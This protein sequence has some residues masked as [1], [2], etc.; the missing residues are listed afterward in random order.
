MSFGPRAGLGGKPQDGTE[1]P[2]TWVVRSSCDRA[3]CVASATTVNRKAGV[4]TYTF[5]YVDEQWLSVIELPDGKCQDKSDPGFRRYTLAPQPD[6]SLKGEIIAISTSGGCNSRYSVTATRTGDADPGVQVTDPAVLPPRVR[7][8]AEGFRGRYHS[9]Q[10]YTLTE[11]T[12][13]R[14]EN[15]YVVD[16]LCVR[17]GDRCASAVY[18]SDSFRTIEYADQQWTLKVTSNGTC[19][20]NGQPKE[21]IWNEEYPL[22]TPTTDPIAILAGKGTSE[23][24]SEGC[25]GGGEYDETYTRTGD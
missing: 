16:T 15:D 9:V 19:S 1:D 10:Q 3:G 21:T 4:L 6:G 18:N 5:D 13:T 14:F 2:V 7:S 22:P 8:P 11:Q 23:V 17:T 12:D 20:G 25:R 24:I